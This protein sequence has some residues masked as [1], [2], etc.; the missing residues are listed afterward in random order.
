MLYVFKIVGKKIKYSPKRE[1]ASCSLRKANAAGNFCDTIL[2]PSCWTVRGALS[3][4]T[5]NNWAVSQELLDAVLKGRVDSRARSQVIDV[6]TQMQSF[7]FFFGI[8]LEVLVL[9]HTD[10]SSS[11]LRYTQMH[12]SYYK[13]QVIAKICFSSLQGM[14]E[15]ASFRMFFWKN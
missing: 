10:N 6:Q 1:G 12:M 2:W 9:S 15:E 3:Q 5:L 4:S 13:A 8:Q 11:T 14:R 7:N